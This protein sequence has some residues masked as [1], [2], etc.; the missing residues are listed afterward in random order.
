MPFYIGEFSKS[1]DL[2][3]VIHLKDPLQTEWLRSGDVVER[4]DHIFEWD[5]NCLRSSELEGWRSTGD[6]MCDEALESM[7]SSTSSSTGVDLLERLQLDAASHPG[8]PSQA[9]LDDVSRPPPDDIAASP[10][11]IL[12]AQAFFLQHSVAI[13]Q[14]L[15]HFSLAGGFASPRITRVLQSVSYLVPPRKNSNPS[16]LAELTPEM[17]DRTY[18]RLLETFQFV[19]DA[20]GCAPA[21]TARMAGD[22]RPVS[23]LN[24][25]GDGWK[26]ALRVR[27]LHGVARRRILER[28][29]FSN[30][31]YSVE[32]DGVPINQ[33]D[34][35][36]TLGSF[37][38]APLWCLKR[39]YPLPFPSPP[40]SQA[41][42]FIAMWR[43]IGFYLGIDPAI[44]RKHFVSPE[45]ATKFLAS[46]ILHLLT[47]ESPPAGCAQP[48]FPTIP[49]L[50]ASSDRP[51]F[52][53]PFEHQCALT[54]YLLGGSLSNHLGV[55]PTPV[56]AELRLLWSLTLAQ[57]P[58]I[59][60]YIYPRCGWRRKRA[61]LTRE[62]LA[63]VVR[64]QLGMRRTAFRPRTESGDVG[65][66]VLCMEAV[67]PDPVGGTRLVKEYRALMMEMAVVIAGS[68][69]L[70]MSSMAC[71]YARQSGWLD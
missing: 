71:W 36:A 24:P 11:E 44:L 5:S 19:L 56:R 18:S 50:L 30:S 26:A 17:N 37:S 23:C 33:E 25:G 2:S 65:E 15:M 47:S 16:E 3:H 60:S 31:S 54:R 64:F 67:K 34:M 35:A 59:F 7:F 61:A 9:L 53:K 63:R 40:K 13:M 21:G 38:A 51:P 52:P 29:K 43:H 28:Q 57:L 12:E 45:T 27:L 32:D 66:G 69:I 49:I 4:W 62:A 14:C 41:S 20:M 70:L 1:V 22:S 39:L 10:S 6:P 55:P 46:T 42:S 58:M 68:T 48:V 8:G